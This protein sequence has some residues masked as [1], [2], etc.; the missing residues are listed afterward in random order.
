M[1]GR[2]GKHASA[3]GATSDSGSCSGVRS[4]VRRAVWSR[5]CCLHRGRHADGRAV[6]RCDR[7][8][9]I[10][11]AIGAH[12]R[13]GRQDAEALLDLIEGE[14]RKLIEALADLAAGPSRPSSRIRYRPSPAALLRRTGS[15]CL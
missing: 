11:A 9:D 6:C 12:Q 13:L 7:L 2:N 10:V 4:P 3:A 5:R 14:A 1:T 8:N 15:I